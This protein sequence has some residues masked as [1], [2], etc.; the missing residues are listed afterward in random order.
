MIGSVV[1]LLAG[2]GASTAAFTYATS[3]AFRSHTAALSVVLLLN[4]LMLLLVMASNVMTQLESTC[5]VIST[6]NYGFALLPGYNLGYGLLQLALFDNGV[7]VDCKVRRGLGACSAATRGLTRQ[8]G[9]TAGSRS[10]RRR[11]GRVGT[12]HYIPL[13]HGRA[14]PRDGHRHRLCS[15]YAVD[16][17]RHHPRAH[18]PHHP[19]SQGRRC[20]GGGGA[21]EA[22]RRGQ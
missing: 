6:L 9:R 22:R 16:S 8:V 18:S 2:Y 3:F 13:C 5:H 1:A 10:Q 19:L 17:T 14:V 21:G 20:G 12:L 11:L 7:K 15:V 4:L